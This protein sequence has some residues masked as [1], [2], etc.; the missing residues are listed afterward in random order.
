MGREAT[1][2]RMAGYIVPLEERCEWVKADGGRC[3]QKRRTPEGRWCDWHETAALARSKYWHMAE[4][5][6]DLT[7]EEHLSQ[8]LKRAWVMCKELEF[9]VLD[10]GLSMDAYHVPQKETETRESDDPKNSYVSVKEATLLGAHPV[11]LHYLKEREH[12]MQIVKMCISAGLAARQVAVI[13]RYVESLIAA[14]MTLA[15][16]LGHDPNDPD[17]RRAIMESVRQQQLA[18][19]DLTPKQITEA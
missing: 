13:E 14:Q 15:E 2:D 6:P 10:M 16:T 11:I 8:L 3:R 19:D 7:V 12:H 9:Q 17:T 1:V 4:H 18:L 5:I